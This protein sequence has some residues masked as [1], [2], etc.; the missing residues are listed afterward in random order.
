MQNW[1]TY[2]VLIVVVTLS[3]LNTFLMSV[4]ERTR[5]FGL[6][7][8]LGATP[9]RIG[10]M[11]LL[12]SLLLTLLG[13]AIGMLL[14]LAVSLY[15]LRY[16]FTFPGLKEIHA[17]FGLPGV[18]YPKITLASMALGPLVILSATLLA[19]LYP[20]TRLRKLDPVEAMHTV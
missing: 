12:E 20:A 7:L 3:I 6:L 15:F 11:V 5:E 14:G 17:Q 2:I 18:I 19:A 10:T 1:F 13:L 16:G 8:A 4:L 9:R